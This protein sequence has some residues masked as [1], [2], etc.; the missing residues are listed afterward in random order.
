MTVDFVA[1]VFQVVNPGPQSH[2]AVQFIGIARRDAAV[3]LQMVQHCLILAHF[4]PFLRPARGS[5]WGKGCYCLSCRSH[6]QD[7]GCLIFVLPVS[8]EYLIVCEFCPSALYQAP[9]CAAVPLKDRFLGR[10]YGD[11]TKSEFA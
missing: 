3:F 10:S 1:H 7:R 2:D 8:D 11:N 5:R 4:L 9:W 6:G